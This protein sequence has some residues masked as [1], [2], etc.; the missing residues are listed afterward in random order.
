MSS[1][2]EKVFE[3][4]ALVE[5][6]GHQ[7]IAGRVTEQV[8]AGAGFVRVDVPETPGSPAHTRWYNP[9]AVY[10]MTPTDEAT[11]TRLAASIYIPEV[12]PLAAVSRQLPD[13]GNFLD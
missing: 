3:M 10:G 2:D 6:F 7:R 11:A 13:D 5:L 1:N 9:S 4:W 8:I 12:I